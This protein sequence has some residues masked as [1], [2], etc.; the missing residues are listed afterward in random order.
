[1][2]LH[3]HNNLQTWAAYVGLADLSFGSK[4]KYYLS[5]ILPSA[6]LKH[7]SVMIMEHEDDIP[8][9]ANR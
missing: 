9:A 6:Y 4:L 7:G 1:M 2:V 3:F 8:H 5:T